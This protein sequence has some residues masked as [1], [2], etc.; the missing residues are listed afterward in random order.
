MCK[1]GPPSFGLIVEGPNC[2]VWG[3]EFGHR[4]AK[5]T[6]LGKARLALDLFCQIPVWST[7]STPSM[8]TLACPGSQHT[9]PSVP[10]SATP[11]PVSESVD[12]RAVMSRSTERPVDQPASAGTTSV[13][14]RAAAPMARASPPLVCQAVTGATGGGPSKNRP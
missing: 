9:S 3:P 5:R 4:H 1:K 10:K 7:V 14:A 2:S 13:G 11:D 12:G 6:T 8:A